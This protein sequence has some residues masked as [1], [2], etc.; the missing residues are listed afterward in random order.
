[1]KR[2]LLGGLLALAAVSAN[3][4]KWNYELSKSDFSVD[5]KVATLKDKVKG[6]ELSVS[7][8]QYADDVNNSA[9]VSI[10]LPKSVIAAFDCRQSC[11]AK[12]NV[13]GDKNAYPPIR[14]LAFSNFKSYGLV[15]KSSADFLEILRKS[16]VVKVLL[17]IGGGS[18][19]VATFKMDEPFSD[20]KL[21]NVK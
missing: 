20:D 11:E 19:D 10:D 1:M 6:Y 9:V 15:S 4:E 18:Y 3:A 2:L 5:Y 7:M 17:P 14:I 21:K 16:K 13:D 12:L 8:Q